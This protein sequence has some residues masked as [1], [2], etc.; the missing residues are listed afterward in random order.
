MLDPPW[1]WELI[2]KIIWP[3]VVLYGTYLHRRIFTL[4]EFARTLQKE[5][6]K[7]EAATIRQYA[8]REAVD[9]LESKLVTMLMRIDDKVDRILERK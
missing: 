2:T 6:A 3:A 5:Q 7:F 4:E 1:F 8:T 9:Q